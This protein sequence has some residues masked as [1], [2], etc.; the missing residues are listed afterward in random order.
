[1][2]VDIRTQLDELPVPV[3]SGE[4]ASARVRYAERGP[5]WEVYWLLGT[6]KMPTGLTFPKVRDAIRAAAYLNERSEP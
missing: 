4:L 1:M 5:T 6:V 2:N 3:S